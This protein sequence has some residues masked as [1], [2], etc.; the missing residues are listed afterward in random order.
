ML[1]CRIFLPDYGYLKESQEEKLTRGGQIKFIAKNGLYDITQV[2]LEI[3]SDGEII[4]YKLSHKH[5]VRSPSKYAEKLPASN[6][7]IT[8]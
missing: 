5:P 2:I 3:E 7:L 4:Q 8:G 1:E 6:P